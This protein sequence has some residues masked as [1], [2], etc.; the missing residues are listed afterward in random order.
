MIMRYEYD[1]LGRNVAVKRYAKGVIGERLVEATY[2][3]YYK[4]TSEV[5]EHRT[6]DEKG[7]VSELYG[8]GY[9]DAGRE[10]YN[11][12]VIAGQD[13]ITKTTYNEKGTVISKSITR[14]GITV[15]VTEY[16]P[17]K[18]EIREYKGGETWWQPEENMGERILYSVSTLTQDGRILRTE[19]YENRTD[20]TSGK[21]ELVVIRSKEYSY[22]PDSDKLD[23]EEIKNDLEDG[24]VS[25]SIYDK[26]GRITEMYNYEDGV[27]VWSSVTDF[28]AE[29]PDFP[30]EK[31]EITRVFERDEN[32]DKVMTSE[33]RKK[34]FPGYMAE[35]PQ[36][37][38]DNNGRP[39][40]YY[41]SELVDGQLK[42][43]VHVVVYDDGKIKEF[44]SS[45][46]DKAEGGKSVTYYNERGS[47][48][49]EAEYDADGNIIDE[50]ITEYEYFDQ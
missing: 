19:Y 42:D 10:I 20:E 3:K 6:E 8:Y 5:I 16:D 23:Y 26:Q 14:D 47:V 17:E 41:W 44:H 21:E 15:M 18:N 32:G 45:L 43:R 38:Y 39:R 24:S 1:D 25:R 13:T 40:V 11:R 36:Q 35:Y 30:G 4:D 48:T 49:R 46:Y 50:V 27:E 22:Y 12:T 33:I 2:M 29:D 7:N 9:D 31:V 37:Y 28:E 34:F